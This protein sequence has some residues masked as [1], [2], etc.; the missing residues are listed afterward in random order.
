[1]TLIEDFRWWMGGLRQRW[2]G[3]A[4]TGVY[5]DLAEAQ[6]EIE[7]LQDH[8]ADLKAALVPFDDLA[9]LMCFCPRCIQNTISFQSR[10]GRAILCAGDFKVAQDVM[11][12]GGQR[13]D[14]EVPV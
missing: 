12:N 11:A 6:A 13:R 9:A 10:R 8:V 3:E 4:V 5:A 7:R 14:A 2:R 1:M